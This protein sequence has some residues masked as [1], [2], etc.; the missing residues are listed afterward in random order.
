MPAKDVTITG[1][2]TVNKYKRCEHH[3]SGRRQGEKSSREI[4][5]DHGDGFLIDSY[6]INHLSQ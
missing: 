3:P 1:T 2:F 6:K 4:K 5:R